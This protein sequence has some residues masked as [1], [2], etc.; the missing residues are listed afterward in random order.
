M[1]SAKLSS[2]DATYD[3]LVLTANV[4]GFEIVYRTSYNY[5]NGRYGDRQTGVA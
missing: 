3:L 1:W 2:W 5:E 4:V